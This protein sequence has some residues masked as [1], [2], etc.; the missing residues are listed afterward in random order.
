MRSCHTVLEPQKVL[1][2]SHTKGGPNVERIIVTNDDGYQSMGIELL[3]EI[4]TGAR[5]QTYVIAPEENHSG[6]AH[7]ISFGDL[8]VRRIAS[9]GDQRWF[10]VKGTPVD[11]V[12]LGLSS[13]FDRS[14]LCVLSGI[15]L[16]W[17]LGRHVMT[18]ATVAA[19]REAAAH[20]VP[21]IAFSASQRCSWDHVAPMIARHLDDWIAYAAS[22]PGTY[23]N[24][25]LP[26]AAT[27]Q[28]RW[29]ALDAR[30]VTMR[31]MNI[32]PSLLGDRIEYEWVDEGP[33]RVPGI[34]GDR[35]AVAEGLI[36]V[37]ALH[38]TQDDAAPFSDDNWDVSNG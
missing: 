5:F 4:A 23:L 33:L 30:P 21:A 36:S 24:I 9:R 17:N 11:C 20:G 15:N 29:T 6:R 34:L 10:A 26:E 27:K 35:E 19:A 8:H 14:P 37:T 7:S 2:F 28:W 38:A 25:N 31:V 1:T 22:R 16:G 13:Y 32:Q 18:S 3:A 12:R